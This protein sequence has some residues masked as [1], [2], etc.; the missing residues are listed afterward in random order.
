MID[1][2]DQHNDPHYQAARAAMVDAATYTEYV[3]FQAD[4]LLDA[5]LPHL[6]AMI[7]AEEVTEKGAHR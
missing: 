7:E 2:N 6:R 3:S 1:K 5:A 4:I